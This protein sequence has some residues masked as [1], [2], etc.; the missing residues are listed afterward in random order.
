MKTLIKL[1]ITLAAAI[2][3]LVS[4]AFRN[5]KDMSDNQTICL[6]IKGIIKLVNNDSL[7]RKP[8][9]LTTMDNL[10]KIELFESGNLIDSTIVKSKKAFGFKLESNKIYGIRMSKKGFNSKIIS[11]DTRVDEKKNYDPNELH[12]FYFTTDL[13]NT[14]D[15]AQ[16]DEDAKDFPCAVIKF[17]DEKRTFDFCRKYHNYRKDVLLR[18][19]RKPKNTEI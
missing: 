8:S 1:I 18:L 6:E 16:L 17:F 11:I 7:L 15:L 4:Y 13:I 19:E 10:I 5:N 14:S 12:K 9:A 2:I 3:L